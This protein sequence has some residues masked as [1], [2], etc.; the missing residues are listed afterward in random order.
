MGRV[1]QMRDGGMDRWWPCSCSNT[2]DVFE[3][4]TGL[5]VES[6][7]TIVLPTSSVGGRPP[8]GPQPCTFFSSLSVSKIQEC[9]DQHHFFPFDIVLVKACRVRSWVYKRRTSLS[10]RCI[11]GISRR[12]TLRLLSRWKS[13]L[14]IKTRPSYFYIITCQSLGVNWSFHKT[15]AR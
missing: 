10:E 7:V 14:T 5:G 8:G 11:W 12:R 4:G 6:R 3:A 1:L 15:P 2:G 9:N 13:Y